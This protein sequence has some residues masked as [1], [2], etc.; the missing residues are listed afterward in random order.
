MAAV[1]RKSP[2][3]LSDAT[4]L[5]FGLFDH[6]NRTTHQAPLHFC[7]RRVRWN[8][9]TTQS[10]LAISNMNAALLRDPALARHPS[11]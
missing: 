8:N 1:R 9:A 11:R 7:H 4:T 10:E 2:A 6:G 5:R 3:C